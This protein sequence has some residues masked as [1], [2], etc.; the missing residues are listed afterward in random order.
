[1]YIKRSKGGSRG[2]PECFSR[3]F[4][5]ISEAFQ[6]ISCGFTEY[7]EISRVFQGGPWAILGILGGLKGVKRSSMDFSG[8]SRGLQGASGTLQGHFRESQV[9]FRGFQSASRF[10]RG[11]PDVFQVVSGLLQ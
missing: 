7:R 1:M 8:D 5:R 10:H 3:A 6:G 4:R 2:V 11:V 9:A